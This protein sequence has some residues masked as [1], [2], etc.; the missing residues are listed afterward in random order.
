MAYCTWPN[1]L[2]IFERAGDI[3]P[4]SG[5]QALIIAEATDLAD[6]YLAP[7]I[8]TPIEPDTDAGYSAFVV[9]FTALLAADITAVRRYHGDDDISQV[10]YDGHIFTGTKWGHMAMGMLQARRQAK[11]ALEIDITEPEAAGPKLATSFTTTDGRVEVRYSSGY[12]MDTTRGLYVFTI[13]G[14]SL[15]VAGE[16]LNIDCVRD[17]V[18]IWADKVITSSGWVDVQHGLQVRFLDGATP[19]W[20][21]AE[22]FTV[23]CE[24][25]DADVMSEGV[26]TREWDLS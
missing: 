16:D 6:V 5:A 1:V 18:A 11:A 23:T 3:E 4:D 19:T 26:T 17:G 20:E 7:L 2:T 12:F 10:D 13:D 24:P 9:R 15:S 21:D 8:Q 14:G 25:M 22:T